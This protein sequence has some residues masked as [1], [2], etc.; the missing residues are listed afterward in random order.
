MEVISILIDINAYAALK[1]GNKQ[2]A[3][4]VSSATR[5]GLS[6][7]V[8]GELLSGFRAG[9]KFEKNVSDL[10]LFASSPGVEI[11][12]VSQEISNRYSSLTHWLRG[13]GRPIPTNGFVFEWS[14]YG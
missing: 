5:I 8:I 7:I 4:I 11:V 13:L 2:A 14:T 3:E 10:Q 12:S 6:V 1:R 9:R